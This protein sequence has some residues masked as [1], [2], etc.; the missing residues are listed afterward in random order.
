MIVKKLEN[1]DYKEYPVIIFG[2]GPAGITVALELEKNNINSIIIEAG[3]EFYSDESQ[4][5]YKGSTNKNLISDISESRLRQ[6]GGT[7]GTWG[8]W[9]KP[10]ETFNLKGW[11][12]T[13][14]S[15]KRYQSKTCEILNIKNQF[16]NVPIS[17]NFNQ[18]EFQYSDVRFYDKYEEHIKKSKKIILVLNTQLSYFEGNDKNVKT[19]ICISGNEIKK[20]NSK[21]FILS[22]GGIENSRILLWSKVKSPMLLKDN[23]PIGKYWM[24]HSWILAGAG[25]IDEKKL[26]KIMNNSY[27][28]YEGPLHIA[29]NENFK[30][31]ERILSGAVYMNKK[32]NEKIYKEIIKDIL[33]IA[34]EYGKKIASMIFNKSLK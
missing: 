8:G 27:L 32:E 18:I 14:E 30:N 15:L 9:C 28:D 25:V 34:P 19:A 29:S 6:F 26:A 10:L 21:F 2:S 24:S 20:I 16:R 11:P 5:F 33:C 7:T 17:K 4:E 3:G 1:I 31:I 23:L 13:S 12:I 22:C